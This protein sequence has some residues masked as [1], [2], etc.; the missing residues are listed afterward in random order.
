M[1]GQKG[2]GVELE[3]R[4]FETADFKAAQEF[5]FFFLEEQGPA[6]NL[7]ILFCPGKHGGEAWQFPFYG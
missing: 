3:C 5:R 7:V 6:R 1:V 2:P 4:K